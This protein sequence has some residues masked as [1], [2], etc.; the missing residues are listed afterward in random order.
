MVQV[1]YSVSWQHLISLFDSQKAWMLAA[2]AEL[3]LAPQMAKAINHI[4]AG[5]SRTMSELADDLLCDASNCTGIVDRL[6]SRGF[7]ERRPSP[8]DRRAKCIVLTA[9]GKRMQKRIEEIMTQIPPAIAALSAADQ[10]MLRDI[11]ERALA[12]A[13]EQRAAG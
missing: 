4:P 10:R 9:A 3:D 8:T 7:V 6:E 5:G 12:V 13:E 11:I 1:K 2:F